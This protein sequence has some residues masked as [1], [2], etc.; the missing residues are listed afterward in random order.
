MY[1]KYHDLTK[2]WMDQHGVKYDAIV[3]GKPN[4]DYYVDDKNMSI[5]EFIK[6]RKI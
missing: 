2:R 4:A 6:R 3:F 1:E 5:D